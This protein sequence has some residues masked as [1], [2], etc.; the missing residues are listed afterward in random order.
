M[1]FPTYDHEGRHTGYTEV[2]FEGEYDYGP[3]K[4]P[5]GCQTKLMILLTAGFAIWLFLSVVF[6]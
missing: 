1:N 4:E 2:R 6:R 5:M 3:Y